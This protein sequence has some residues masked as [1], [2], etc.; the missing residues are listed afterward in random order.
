MEKY[1]ISE[2]VARN[3]TRQAKDCYRIGC[4][5]DMCIIPKI[6]NEPCQM[7]RTVFTL[8]RNL[9]IPAELRR[10]KYYVE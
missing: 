9:G 10:K 1:T 7:K 4:N 2:N 8:V 5:C 3:W 6:M